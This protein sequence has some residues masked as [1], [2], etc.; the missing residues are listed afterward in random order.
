M[1]AEEAFDVIMKI[2]EA[3]ITPSL[4]LLLA[5]EKKVCGGL[6]FS[7]ASPRTPPGA[8]SK[9]PMPSA[10]GEARNMGAFGSEDDTLRGKYTV[11]VLDDALRRRRHSGVDSL[12]LYFFRLR[13]GE[14]T[15]MYFV[16]RPFFA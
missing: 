1:F 16:L 11:N 8:P 15:G 3:T 6:L 12:F 14:L 2:A 13:L 10:V 9:L 7:L 5:A 4:A